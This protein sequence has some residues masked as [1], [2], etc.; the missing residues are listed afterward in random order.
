MLEFCSF[1][2]GGI[3]DGEESWLVGFSR[4]SSTC[5]TTHKEISPVLGTHSLYD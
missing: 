3:Q 1:A 4:L 5:G 2:H